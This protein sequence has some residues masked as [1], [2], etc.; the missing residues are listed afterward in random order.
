MKI[1]I[2]NKFWYRRGGDCIYAINL[3]QMLRE[4]GI[5]TAVFAMRHPENLKTDFDSYFPSEIS[6][7]GPKAMMGT[8]TRS[9]GLGAVRNKFNILLDDFC[10][11]VV[12]LNN[13]HTQ[14]SPVLAE[15]AHRRGIKVVWTLHDYKLLCPRYDCRQNG[16]QQC[17]ECF[18]CK[19]PVLKH[20]CMKNSFPAS[21]LAFLEAVCWNRKRLERCVDIFICPSEFIRQK[22]LQG[23]FKAGK[24]VHLCNSLD[25]SKCK[26]DDY[27]NRADYCCYVGRLSAEK[28]VGTLI[29]AARKLPDRKF[30]IVGDGPLSNSLTSLASDNVK[31]VGRKDW[32]EIKDIVGKA[33]FSVMPS[34]CFENNPLSVIEAQCLGTPVLGAEIGGIPELID[35]NCGMTFKSADSINLEDKMKQ[36]F[37]KRFDYASIA[38]SSLKKYDSEAYFNN[39]MD[40]YAE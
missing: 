15:I 9:L 38:S 34:E 17:E 7:N 36:M 13:I 12:H 10:P 39:L 19:L 23:G 4:N 20:K 40:L 37:A 31:F 32:P 28:G 18:R 24:L 26:L 21:V 22:M 27:D 14:L 3:E 33:A 8:A 35:D 30:V 6:F 1:L 16:T 29:A 11:D 25:T 2:A 5:E